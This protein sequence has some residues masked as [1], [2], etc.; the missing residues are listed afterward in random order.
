MISDIP[1]GYGKGY[2]KG[3]KEEIKERRD[4]ITAWFNFSDQC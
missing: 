3:Q 4:D 2:G 1:K